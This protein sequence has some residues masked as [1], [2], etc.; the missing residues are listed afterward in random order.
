VIC[1][2]YMVNKNRLEISI[3]SLFQDVI[4]QLK[5]AESVKAEGKGKFQTETGHEGP[6]GE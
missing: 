3:C 4:P 1:D 5:S 6:E 2:E